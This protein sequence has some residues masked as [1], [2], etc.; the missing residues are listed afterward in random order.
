MSNRTRKEPF[1]PLQTRQPYDAMKH[2]IKKKGPDIPLPEHLSASGTLPQRRPGYFQSRRHKLETPSCSGVATRVRCRGLS[3]HLHVC[4][5]PYVE[6]AAAAGGGDGDDAGEDLL[7]RCE[8]PS[9]FP[10][11][12]PAPEGLASSQSLIPGESAE[13]AS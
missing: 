9:D 12:R 1:K 7:P 13:Q 11:P 3:V 8:R 4:L 6:P 2:N 5:R 10:P